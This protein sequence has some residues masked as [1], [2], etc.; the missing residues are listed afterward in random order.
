MMSGR[1]LVVIARPNWQT[2]IGVKWIRNLQSLPGKLPSTACLR[3]MT[4][5]LVQ[6]ETTWS[7]ISRVKSKQN[8]C[9]LQVPVT[10]ILQHS[11]LS[12]GLASSGS[13]PFLNKDAYDW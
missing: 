9:N 10:K 2:E 1:D 4:G 11:P 3:H 6:S 5:I 8:R 12:T 7:L 13:F